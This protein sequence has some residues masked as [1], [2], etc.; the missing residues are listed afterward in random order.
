MN[1]RI[2]SLAAVAAAAIAALFAVPPWVSVEAACR[3]AIIRLPDLGYGGGASAFN[4]T[5]VT[6]LVFDANGL[7]HPATW[8]RGKLTV[9]HGNGIGVGVVTDINARGDI[10]GTNDQFSRAWE[11]RHGAVRF[12]RHLPGRGGPGSIAAR[13]INSRG[14][15]AGGA[16]D[17]S[18][19]LRWASAAAAPA[20]LRPR[21]GD[22]S[23]FARGINDAGVAA[24]ETDQRDSTPHAAIWDRLGRIRVLS[25]AYGPGTPADLF[26]DQQCRDSGQRVLPHRCNGPHGVR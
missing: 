18:D 26:R 17:S 23:S 9:L 21:P 11:L 19:A 12:L 3:P 14:Q 16:G 5:T 20:I 25:G 22:A 15:I 7:V 4:G 2:M 24:G 1:R 13:R 6:G 8:R 10:I